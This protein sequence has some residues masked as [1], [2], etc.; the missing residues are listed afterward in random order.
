MKNK[1]KNIIRL[2]LNINSKKMYDFL[3][4]NLIINQI[5]TT[6]IYNMVY[7]YS[8]YFSQ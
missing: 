1:T 5:L 3:S 8:F 7:I 6:Y 4:N 2:S